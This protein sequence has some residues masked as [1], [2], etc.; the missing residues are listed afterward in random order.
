M[1]GKDHR[2]FFRLPVASRVFIEIE[3]APPGSIGPGKVARC[4][5][6]DVSQSGLRVRLD[7]SVTVG[8]ILQIGVELP[9]E[10]EPFYL[11]GQVLWRMRDKEHPGS[12]IA[13]F[14]VLN[15]LGSDIEHWEAALMEMDERTPA[16]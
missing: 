7:E 10:N 3:S 12:W 2:R 15:A 1:T 9:G 13:G 4:D 14:E 8:A 16:P 6:L 11:V 5:T